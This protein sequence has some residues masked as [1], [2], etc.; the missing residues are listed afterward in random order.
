MCRLFFYLP[1]KIYK[2]FYCKIKKNLGWIWCRSRSRIPSIFLN[3]YSQLCLMSERE[4]RC[5]ENRTHKR[6]VVFLSW[7]FSPFPIKQNRVKPKTERRDHLLQHHSPSPVVEVVLLFT[8]KRILQSNPIFL[9]SFENGKKMLT[10]KG[11]WMVLR[12]W[13]IITRRKKRPHTHLHTT[14]YLL[15]LLSYSLIWKEILYFS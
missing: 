14:W 15:H 1:Q 11:K 8:Y 4:L 5:I 3:F 10:L 7:F 9:L 13:N 2:F 6:L 12:T